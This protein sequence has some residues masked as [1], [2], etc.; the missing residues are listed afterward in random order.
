[1]K[2]SFFL[3]ADTAVIDKSSSQIS[4]FNVLEQIN[5]PTFPVTLPQFSV[6]ATMDREEDEDEIVE[7]KLQ[8]TLN[9]R[10][11][12]EMPV[13]LDFQGAR[14]NHFVGQI[15]GL[16]VDEPGNLTAIF[17]LGPKRV[18]IWNI[19][20]VGLEQKEDAATL[21]QVKQIKKPKSKKSS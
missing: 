11:L 2:A 5:T 14:R 9:G 21:V 8:W 6:V 13:S 10:K 4:I 18:G 7:L 17:R 19:D 20:I 12:L 3:C 16:L 1:M 15:R